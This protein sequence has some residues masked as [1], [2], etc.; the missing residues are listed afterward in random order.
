MKTRYAA[1]APNFGRDDGRG[2][3]FCAGHF[4]RTG[5]RADP[6]NNQFPHRA[7]RCHVR[8]SGQAVYRQSAQRSRPADPC[9]YGAVANYA[10]AAAHAEH[11]SAQ[12]A[13]SAP[14][15]YVPT[16][17]PPAVPVATVPAPAPVIVLRTR[18]VCTARGLRT[19]ITLTP[20]P[21]VSAYNPTSCRSGIGVGVGVLAGGW[22]GYGWRGGYWRGG[23]WHR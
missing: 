8:I 15:V 1:A 20:Y 2:G 6:R 18:G 23:G 5:G 22:G 14:P 16:P 4:I 10:R 3:R 12:V 7:L 11:S 17:P 13:P 21:C 9:G 19:L